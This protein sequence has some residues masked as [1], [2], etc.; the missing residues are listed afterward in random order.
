MNIMNYPII[1]A[2]STAMD[3]NKAGFRWKRNKPNKHTFIQTNKHK[4]VAQKYLQVPWS[5]R[6]K[7]RMVPLLIQDLNEKVR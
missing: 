2:L 7:N 5:K 3:Q 1:G 4:F 6:L